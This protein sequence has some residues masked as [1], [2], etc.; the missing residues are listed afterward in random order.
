MD[1]RRMSGILLHPTS[2]PGPFG[3]GDLGPE[4]YRFVKFLKKANQQLWQ[5]LPLGPT[6]YGN[7]PYMCFS[8]FGGNSLLIS[9]E[10]LLDEELLQ[11]EDLAGIP[12]FPDEHV[13]YAAVL[14]WKIPLLEKAFHNFQ[15]RVAIRYPDDFY[16]FCEQNAFWL[17][18]YALFA[19]LK[20][21]HA[22]QVWP[23]WER[24]IALRESEALLQWRNRLSERV[25]FRKFIQYTFFK[26]WAGLKRFCHANDILVIGDIPIYVAHDSAEV[27]ANQPL[28]H[29]DEH[30]RPLV[31]AG[32]PPDYFSA[33][34][35]RWGNPIYR[36]EKMAER[37]YQWWTDRF[38]LNFSLVDIVRLDHFRGFEAYWEIPASART[39]V[40]GRWVKGPGADLFHAVQR[41]LG[42]LSVI[43]EDLGIITP[44][45]DAL[46][47]ELKFPGMRILQMA[48]GHDAKASEYRPHHHITNCAAYTATHD[49]N[50]T[51]GWFT[52]EPGTQTTQS[53][54]EIAVERRNALA[55]TGTDGKAIHWDFIRLAMGSVASLAIFPLQDALGL[56][57]ASRMNR[58]GTLA[59][60]WEWRVQ[61]EAL[62]PE[63]A[64]R[65]AHLSTVYERNAYPLTAGQSPVLPPKDPNQ[66]QIEP[67]KWIPHPFN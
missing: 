22:G 4:A 6:G 31:I 15:S 60:N 3:I 54:E 39:A 19:A 16:G 45:V 9:P 25:Q 38:R 32:V 40:D 47:E 11:K 18:D 29:L 49:H 42:P 2:L 8:A 59:G 13:D 24:A 41:A 33:T 55:Y 12:E 62:T 56:G 5:I 14:A 46:R 63:I 65:L 48:F 28:F 58:P 10:I 34:G 43:A 17:E 27:W 44:E 26:Q 52:A 30:G 57:S 37:G 50:T 61:P 51:A 64:T 36:W 23:S 53:A 21:A 20:D 67:A 35:Q 66:D 1:F 7:S